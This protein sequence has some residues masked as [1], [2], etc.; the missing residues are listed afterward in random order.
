MIHSLISKL[1]S[2]IELEAASAHCDIPCKI[3]DP[4]GAQ[5]AA[6]TIVRMVDL[7]AET[8][9]NGDKNSV[10]YLNS[11][12]RFITTKEEHGHKCKDEIRVIWGDYFKAPQFEKH[13]EIHDV[14]HNIMMLA[15]K[16]K[17]EIDRDNAVALVE[18]VNQFAEIFWDTKD[19]KTKRAVCPYP[20]SL[21]VVY[22]DL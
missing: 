11:M 6:L 7:I 2:K 22:P 8:E 19:V 1:D 17:Q 13:P 15:S 20:P 12:S 16:C 5:I 4:S 14:T 3:Y 18:A 9:A 10:G 21:E